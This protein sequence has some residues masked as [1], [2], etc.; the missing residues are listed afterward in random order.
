MVYKQG[1]FRTDEHHVP[2]GFGNK[3]L[4]SGISHPCRKLERSEKPR[5]HATRVVGSMEFGGYLS[6][7]QPRWGYKAI[8]FGL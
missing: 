2:S 6:A 3:A 5:F 8:L 4:L 7:E 1:Y